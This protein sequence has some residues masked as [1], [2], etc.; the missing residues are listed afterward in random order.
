MVTNRY[1]SAIVDAFL[2]VLITGGTISVAL[3]APNSLLFLDKPV[4]KY[5]NKL[6]KRSRE[7]ELDRILLYMRKKKLVDYSLTESYQHGIVVTSAGKKRAQNADFDSMEIKKPKRWDGRWRLVFY[8]IPEAKKATRN[9]LK[10]K[11]QDLGFCLLQRS[12]WIYPYPCRKE[13]ERVAL[14]YQ[15]NKYVTYVE[16]Q[17]I[18]NEN[19]LKKKFGL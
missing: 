8:D 7:R 3:I 17:Y 6:D 19:L 9:L 1:T 12:I 14:H 5:L 13:I 15:V 18:D 2:R 11:L 10:I 4:G 16:I